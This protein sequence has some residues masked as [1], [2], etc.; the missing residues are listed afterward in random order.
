MT[1]V[2]FNIL[3]V[4][5]I[6]ASLLRYILTINWSGYQGRLAYAAAAPVAALLGLGWQRVARAIRQRWWGQAIGGQ[7]AL[8]ALPVVG[9]AALTVG[10]LLFLLRPAYARPAL[11]APPVD[12]ARVCQATGSGFYVEAVEMPRSVLPGAT[13]PI[14]VAGYGQTDGQ[15]AAEAALLNWDGAVLATT[16]VNLTWTAR[17]PISQP[18]TLAVPQGT[19]P[20]RGQAVL[21]VG[22]ER[23]DLGW[24]KIAPLTGETA[25]PS[26]PLAAN[27]GDQAALVGYDLQPDGADLR[28]RLYWQA[29]APMAVDYTIFAHLLGADGELLAQHDAQPGNGRYPTTIWDSGEIVV[30]EIVLNVPPNAVPARIA[31]GLYRL[32]TLER[33]AVMG[34]DAGETAVFLPMP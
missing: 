21:F 17:N 9:L 18:V 26:N 30:E 34:D 33:L 25:V 31:V 11:F 7:M 20:A 29:L 8:T 32:D 14:T 5:A 13:L 28:L 22:S 4:G 16:A 3:A 15:A 1:A 23:V 10:C 12:W 2:L 27:F 24:V 6:Y 19:Q